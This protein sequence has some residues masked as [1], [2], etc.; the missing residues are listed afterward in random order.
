MKTST[1]WL[2]ALG[3]TV[4]SAYTRIAPHG[5]NFAPMT[6]LALFGIAFFGFRWPAFAVPLGAQLL[7]DV[8]LGLRADDREFIFHQDS[9]SVYIS[10]LCIAGLGWFLSRKVNAITTLG[11]AFAA[12]LIYFTGTNLSCWITMDIYEKNWKGFLDCIDAALPFY[13]TSFLSDMVY[14]LAFLGV[15]QLVVVPNSKAAGERA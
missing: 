5:W 10:L 9:L 2:L 12:S 11:Y 13:R 1:Y 15:H 14:S 3:L 4:F 6:A 8:L 7:G